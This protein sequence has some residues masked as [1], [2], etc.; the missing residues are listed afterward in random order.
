MAGLLD[1]ARFH[2][3]EV[4]RFHLGVGRVLSLEAEF[5]HSKSEGSFKEGKRVSGVEEEGTPLGRKK[6]RHCTWTPF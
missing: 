6:R 4:I 2:L 3:R 1:K 5:F